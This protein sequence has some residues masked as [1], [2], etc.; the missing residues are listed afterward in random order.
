M[1]Q[2]IVGVGE[3]LWD[4]L[5]DGP[6]LGG[7]PANFVCQA[8]NLGARAALVSCVGSDSQGHE[9]RARLQALGVNT[10]A[11][12]IDPDAPTGTVTVTVEHGE[13]H[14]VIHEN[15]A[16]DRLAVTNEA[17][18]AVEIADALCFG[19]LAQRRP[20]ARQALRRLVA[21][22]PPDALRILDVNLRQAYYSA[23]VLVESLQL[24]NA[25]K[26]N[27]RE[28][29]RLAELLDWRG[30][31]EQ[32]L[33]Q[34]VRDYDL[35]VLAYTRGSKGSW[36]YANGDWSD[37][38]GVPITVRDTVGAGDA[39]TAA[40]ALGVLGE[41]PVDTIN[42]RANTVAAFVASSAGATPPLPPA[43]RA[44]FNV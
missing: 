27:E 16:W 26:L 8:A 24:A 15:V 33:R 25:L 12:Q 30:T 41:W 3:V 10:E 23:E 29:P 20:S 19:T 4:L 11:I 17:L 7:A 18:A 38:P 40:L 14:Y 6:Q 36:L 13:P 1:S 42:D 2:R 5:P 39:F 34:L 22:A 28:L 9:L 21:F 43:L 44:L 31:N 37:H 32:L 35:R